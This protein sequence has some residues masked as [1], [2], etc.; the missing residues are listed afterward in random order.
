[1]RASSVTCAVL[2]FCP[3]HVRMQLHVE[4]DELRRQV[5]EVI[6]TMA[7]L[8]AGP[9][10]VQGSRCLKCKQ[11]LDLP[12]VHFLCHHSY[13]SRYVFLVCGGVAVR[14]CASPP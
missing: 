1:M 7:E 13:H 10:L 9:M 5:D 4:V 2:T 3:S 8:E 11:T 14:K 6:T 12:C